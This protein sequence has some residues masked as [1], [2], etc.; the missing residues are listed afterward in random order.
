MRAKPQLKNNPC[1]LTHLSPDSISFVFN[2]S[3]PPSLSRLLSHQR[4][5]SFSRSLSLSLSHRRLR[6]SLSLSLRPQLQYQLRRGSP[7]RI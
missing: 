5:L 4:D 6:G 2:P 7:R 3:P 1:S